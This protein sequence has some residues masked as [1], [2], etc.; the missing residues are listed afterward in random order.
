M[1][2]HQG[3][4]EKWVCDGVE[5]I[6]AYPSERRG[7]W[8]VGLVASQVVIGGRFYGSSQALLAGGVHARFGCHS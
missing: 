2:A 7:S 8:V 4:E 3:I 6:V 5:A 1:S